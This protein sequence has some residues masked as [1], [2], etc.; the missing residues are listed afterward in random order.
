MSNFSRVHKTNPNHIH[1]R[2]LVKG[3]WFE[4]YSYTQKDWI[5]LRASCNAYPI[6][7]PNEKEQPEYMGEQGDIGDY[8]VKAEGIELGYNFLIWN[9][10]KV[11]WQFPYDKA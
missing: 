9:F 8:I 5:K 2:N 4:A 1:P 10:E 3:D 6:P 11:R 7:E